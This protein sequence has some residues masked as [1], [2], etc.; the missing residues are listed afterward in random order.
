MSR[1]SC[2]AQAMI[3]IKFVNRDYCPEAVTPAER[4]KNETKPKNS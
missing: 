3:R 1:I 4:C 2:F